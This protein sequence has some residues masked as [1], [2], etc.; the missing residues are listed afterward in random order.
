MLKQCFSI[1]SC[2]DSTVLGEDQP[3]VYLSAKCK[4]ALGSPSPGYA[5]LLYIEMMSNP[6][7][8]YICQIGNPVLAN[9]QGDGLPYATLHLADR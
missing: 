8:P 3:A 6:M 9:H 4:V 2:L 5:V 1:V 7:L